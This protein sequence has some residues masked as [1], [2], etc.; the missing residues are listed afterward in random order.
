MSS[1]F[2]SVT[3]QVTWS[4]LTPSL[5]NIIVG[6]DLIPNAAAEIPLGVNLL[7]GELVYNEVLETTLLS[8]SLNVSR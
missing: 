6:I 8:F 2:F 3:F 1:I 7:P 4:T 5:K